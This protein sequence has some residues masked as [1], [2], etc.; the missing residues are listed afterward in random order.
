[1]DR[2][3]ACAN[4][5]FFQM[6]INIYAERRQKPNEPFGTKTRKVTPCDIGDF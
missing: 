1:M 6:H 5:T 3:T 2:Y 4:A